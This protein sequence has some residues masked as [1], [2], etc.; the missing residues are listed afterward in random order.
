MI[1]KYRRIIE[2]MSYVGIGT[3]DPNHPLEVE[4]QVFISNVEQGS[5][6]NLVPFEVYSN[7]DGIIGDTL[8]GARQLRLRVTPSLTTSSNVNIDMG[9]EPTSGEYFYISNPVVDTTLG[10]NAALRIVQAGHVEMESNLTVSGNIVTTNIISSSSL[11]LSSGSLVKVDGSGGLSVTGPITGSTA[12]YSGDVQAATI[13]STGDAF[14]SR[15][16][17]GTASTTRNLTIYGTN[18]SVEFRGVG[19]GNSSTLLLG[20]P[21][22]ATSP[23]KVAIVATGNS[24][25]SR[26][27][28]HFCLDDTASN[29]PAYAAS[30]AN[31]RMT[32]IPSGNVGIGS[33][34]PYTTLQVRASDPRILVG[35]SN[36]GGGRLEFGNGNHGTGRGTG[37][38]N[39]TDGNDVVLY[40][41]GTGGS[42]L[43][44]A[45]GYLKVTSGGYVGIGTDAPRRKLEVYGSAETFE[46]RT[47]RVQIIDSGRYVDVG[48]GGYVYIG[49]REA[50]HSGGWSYAMFQN[51]IPGNWTDASGQRRSFN[52][53]IL[54]FRYFNISN[55]NAGT[56]WRFVLY[57]T[58]NG[59][60]VYKGEW[61]AG[62]VGNARGYMTT[63]SPII[64]LAWGD[65]PGLLMYVYDNTYGGWTCRIGSMWLTYVSD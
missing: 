38:S 59:S 35:D 64:N 17:I 10:S 50:G 13:S 14:A 44:T 57:L 18:P 31:A 5:T 53:V 2:N 21:F 52:R 4:G 40:T 60:N 56:T 46:G 9:I 51:G 12:T 6:T 11:T 20:T 8:E 49:S 62:D 37:H 26:A 24:N 32:I 23:A 47:A 63:S 61:Y 33:T 25:F 3:T 22:D 28:L 36:G 54:N 7:Y 43:R 16:G 34:N 1:L 39:F 27:K 58:R 48:H 30:E 65:V 19:E 41:A 15:V 42:G 45:S 55:G 29:D